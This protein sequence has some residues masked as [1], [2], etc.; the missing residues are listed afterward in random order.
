M[1]RPN[2]VRALSVSLLFALGAVSTQ[3]AAEDLVFDFHNESS[4]VVMEFYAAPTEV[5]NW[6]E[7][8]LGDDVLGSGESTEITIAD[9]REQCEYDFRIV[10]EGDIVV[11]RRGIDLCELG[12]Y[13]LTD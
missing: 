2:G 7:D 9:G 8:I 13:T 11:E 6:E 10:V 3:V 4:Y 5:D 1:N 12:E